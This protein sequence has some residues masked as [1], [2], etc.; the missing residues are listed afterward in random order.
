M[1]GAQFESQAMLEHLVDYAT[2]NRRL[3]RNVTGIVVAIVLFNV[4]VDPYEI[5]G[6][7]SYRGGF[8]PNERFNKVD[9][10][11]AHSEKYDSFIVGSSVMGQFNPRLLELKRPGQ[12]AYNLSFLRGTPAEALDTLRTLQANGVRIKEIVMGI[13]V[14]PFIESSEYVE[15]FRRP[16]PAV[17]GESVASFYLSYVF[18][19]GLV[20][21][22][23]RL[24][25]AFE[26]QPKI[27]FDLRGT[28]EYRLLSYDREILKDQSSFIK[29]Q[30]A[31]IADAKRAK[32]VWVQKRFD[33]LQ[34]L[35]EWLA[36][37]GI[38]AEFFIHPLHHSTLDLIEQ[39]SLTEFRS[40][41]VSILGPVPDYS[42]T[43][44]ITHDDRNYYDRKHYRP[45]VAEE[46]LG[47]IL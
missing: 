39:A 27:A 10:L 42:R 21:G 17:S 31:P 4:F 47:Q 5:F 33:E 7:V 38:R 9:Y 30:M 35:K 1:S 13:D 36:A 16:H 19:S 14:F 15:P 24:S 8:A 20:Q 46:I 23:N 43:D 37:G 26:P 32:F 6:I 40:R 2:W 12:R 44:R 29:R 28:G 3:L 22:I 18:T 45:F 11:L 41:V 34:A 25:H